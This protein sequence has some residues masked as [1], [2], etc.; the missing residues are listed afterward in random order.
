MGP[1]KPVFSEAVPRD[2]RLG[3]PPFGP[4]RP[5]KHAVS[6]E[7]CSDVLGTLRE[8]SRA[9]PDLDGCRQLLELI[10][11]EVQAEQAVLIL[12]NPLTGELEFVV[13]D[14]DPEVPRRYAEY[15][16]GLDPTGLPAYVTGSRRCAGR[17]A[18][19]FGLGPDGGRRLRLVRQHRVLQRLPQERQDPLR[20]GRLP[21]SQHGHSRRHLP[22]SR[23]SAE[24]VLRRGDRRSR[25][26]RAVRRESPGTGSLGKPAVDRAVDGRQGR[27]R[28]R[29][30]GPGAV[31]Q[32]H[33]PQ[34][35]LSRRPV[36]RGAS[37][38]R[39]C[40]FRGVHRGARGLPGRSLRR[41]GG[42]AGG[43]ARPRRA[44]PPHHFGAT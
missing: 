7:R 28:L 23:P 17:R 19:L 1:S 38:G 30:A 26:H 16:C 9:T 2:R 43:G 33:R 10:S 4:S 14:Q 44:R 29:P 40:L 25:S 18:P 37:P 6:P 24:A 5:R 42:L 11:K 34:G 12:S 27:H 35:L 20:P 3:S 36:V 22:A 15:Y 8:V 13:H 39:R 31:L 32:R 21:L 41:R